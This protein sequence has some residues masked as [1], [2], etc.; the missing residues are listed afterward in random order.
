VLYSHSHHSDISVIRPAWGS[1]EWLL[2]SADVSTRLKVWK[3]SN[4]SGVRDTKAQL[5]DSQLNQVITQILFNLKM[6]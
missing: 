3:M 4:I 5:M 1:K 2:A 6:T